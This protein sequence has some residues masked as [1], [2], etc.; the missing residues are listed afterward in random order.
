MGA[1]MPEER[2]VNKNVYPVKKPGQVK[3]I[4]E[5]IESHTESERS[6]EREGGPRAPM[7]DLTGPVVLSPSTYVEKDKALEEEKRR[8]LEEQKKKYPPS[9]VPK[10]EDAFF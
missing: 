7:K 1:M 6:E 3:D 5:G 4:Y 2:D 8:P 9:A 10:D